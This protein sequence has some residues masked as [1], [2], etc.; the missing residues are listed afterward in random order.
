MAQSAGLHRS[1]LAATLF[2]ALGDARPETPARERKPAGKSGV[3]LAHE[4]EG[5]RPAV[6][7]APAPDLEYHPVGRDA[8]RSEL[9]RAFCSS[10][11]EL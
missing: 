11:S 5:A 7:S 6:G 3:P 2:R 4:G 9:K 10:L 1:T 8:E